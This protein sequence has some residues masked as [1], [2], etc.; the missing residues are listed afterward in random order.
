MESED[1]PKVTGIEVDLE[2]RTQVS[3]PGDCT[4]LTSFNIMCT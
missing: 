4:V 3:T 2:A 1:L